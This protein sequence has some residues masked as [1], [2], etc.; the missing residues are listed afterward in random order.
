MRDDGFV[1]RQQALR[2][3]MLEALYEA[4]RHKRHVYS[5]EL[6]HALGFAPEEAEF[7]LGYLSEA[8]LV[9]HK[10]AQVRITARGIDQLEKG[11]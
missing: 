1:S 5:R 6:I 2:Q 11:D 10:S 7:A 9:E 3:T 4:R 8:G